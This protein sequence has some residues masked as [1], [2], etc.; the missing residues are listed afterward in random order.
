MEILSSTQVVPGFLWP[1]SPEK[2]LFPSDNLRN[3][4]QYLYWVYNLA[5]SVGL[6]QATKYAGALLK[7][8]NALRNALDHELC[9][10]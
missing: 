2:Q 5:V 6:A 10:L 1:D 9:N 3:S 7:H 4:G 8:F